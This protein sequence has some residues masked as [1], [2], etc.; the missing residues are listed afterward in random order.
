MAI[1]QTEP[2]TFS[3]D[4][5]HP[6]YMAFFF[7]PELKRLIEILDDYNELNRQAV[8]NKDD[9]EQV[10]QAQEDMKFLDNIRNELTNVLET[11]GP[12][13]PG[14]T[15]MTYDELLKWT[16]DQGRNER[17]LLVWFAEA[18]APCFFVMSTK[19][20]AEMLLD[21][22]PKYDAAWLKSYWEDIERSDQED[23]M[24]SMGEDWSP[25]KA[26]KQEDDDEELKPDEACTDDHIV[27]RIK[28]YIEGVLNDEDPPR[29]W[30]RRDAESVQTALALDGYDVNQQRIHDLAVANFL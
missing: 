15:N 27:E 1:Y 20:L 3:V 12:L 10:L 30:E 16:L 24:K 5:D 14:R 19:E 13:E 17:D 6:Q 29:K 23:L 18:E 28:A 8:K 4:T 9:D 25:L 2:M 11:V 22:I 7:E 21:G 26:T